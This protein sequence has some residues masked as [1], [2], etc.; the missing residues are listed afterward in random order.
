[1]KIIPKFLNI[2]SVIRADPILGF[3]RD[4][5]NSFAIVIA[6]DRFPIVWLKL[7]IHNAIYRQMQI[8]LSD[9][10]ESEVFYISVGNAE[11]AERFPEI[12]K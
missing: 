2:F 7:A 12:S 4:S 11:D 10:C 3:I 9:Y 6:S 8:P 5:L 1:M